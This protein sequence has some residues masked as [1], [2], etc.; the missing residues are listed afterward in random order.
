M[1]FFKTDV[2]LIKVAL[3]AKAYVSS[4]VCKL[5]LNPKV[6]IDNMLYILAPFELPFQR[7]VEY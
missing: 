1:T 7:L 5:S 3:I 2:I 6:S 4:F